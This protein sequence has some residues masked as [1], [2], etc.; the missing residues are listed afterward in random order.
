MKEERY[1][2]I[3]NTTKP[4]NKLW[5]EYVDKET[6]ASSMNIITPKKISTFDTCKHYYDYDPQDS[7]AIC[8]NCGLGHRLVWG[9]QI[10]KDGKI[11]TQKPR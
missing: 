1:R 3:G 2:F 4:G 5:D 11:I 9:I 8:R 10:I 6:G 7:S